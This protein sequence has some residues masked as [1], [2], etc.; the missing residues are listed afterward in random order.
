MLVILFLSVGLDIFD[1]GA[2][3]WSARELA[4]RRITSSDYIRVMRKKSGLNL[5]FILVG[6]LIYAIF[7]QAHF[8]ILVIGFYPF[9]WIRTNYIQQF[10]M[11]RNQISTAI[12]LQV[13]ERFMWLLIILF[14]ELQIDEWAAYIY[15]IIIG[16]F[17]HNFLGSMAL[18][19]FSN[20]DAR[21]SGLS[22]SVL[23]K[24][25]H[26][27]AVSV[28]SD[29]LNLDT[30][31]VAK[32]SSIE[33]SANFGVTQRFRNPL[34]LGLNSFS[35]RLKPIASTGDRN[36]IRRLFMEERTFLILNYLAILSFSAL[37]Y[38][39]GNGLFG[40]E[41]P[42]IN[43]VLALGVLVAVPLS[44]NVISSGFLMSLGSE[45]SVMKIT[46][47]S[48]PL[49]LT[50]VSFMGYFFGAVGSIFSVLTVNIFSSCIF[51]YLSLKSWSILE[52]NYHEL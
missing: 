41:F 6:P 24:S 7:A 10:L 19:R 27:G 5:S 34:L 17:F 16:L 52:N 46:L 26:F 40:A 32:F 4:A 23:Q 36:S 28:V 11:V 38:F 9:L 13:I 30:F 25:K 47:V 37:M 39:L 50:L 33:D 12:K 31:L 14:E 42:H 1:F 49:T 15:P 18:S 35:I 20:D 43:V 44:I 48:V 29:I 45:K 8:A 51:L 21:I 2:C 3:S 22:R